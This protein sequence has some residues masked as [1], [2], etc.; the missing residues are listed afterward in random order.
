MSQATA[1]SD[2]DILRRDRR[3]TSLI[4]VSH[5][6]SHF[7]QLA[8]PPLFYLINQSE[9]ISFALLGALTAA[10]YVTSAVCQP[11]SGFLVDKFGARRILLMGLGLLAGCTT[12]MGILPYYP[13]LF[14][15]SVLAGVGNS[16]FHPCDYSIMNAT[17]SE[18]RIARAFSYHMFGG[19]VGYVSAPVAM[20]AIGTAVGWQPAIVIA[21]AVGLVLFAILW[22]GSRD[23]RDSTHE[24]AESGAA[25]ESF[26]ESIRTL[27]SPP[28]LLCWSFF[29]FVAMGQMGLMTFVPTL[30]K[31][32]YAFEL[33]AAA[34][35][36]SVMIGA[37]MIGV[38]LG[39]Y[40]ADKLRKPD[41]IVTVGYCIATLMVT[42]IWYFELVSWQLFGIFA[43]IGFMYGV[44]FPSRELL[45]RAATP[46]GA[47][48]K[49]FGFVYSGMD[50][51][52]A[53]TPVLFGWFVDT[54]VSRYAF[55]CVGILWVLSIVI[56]LLTNSATKR[57]QY[58]AAG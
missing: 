57:R 6:A 11:L 1:F 18:Q 34:A 14:V 38:L 21:G 56:M 41:V 55:L 51:G 8:L 53:V 26:G 32:I 17:I 15:L 9:G 29:F 12:L 20:T 4:G 7:Y 25:E 43:V 46:K 39:G 48:G 58:L 3:V 22:S 2:A 50:F 13:V 24:R 28:V 5:G 54:G 36:V 40:L 42:S 31:E 47:S 35:F 19:Y 10:F 16:V 27:T 44:V 33:E 45:V 30:M 52:A 23:F 37:I 49:V